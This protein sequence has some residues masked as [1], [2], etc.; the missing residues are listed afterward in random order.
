MNNHHG[1]GVPGPRPGHSALS[2]LITID[3]ATFADTYWGEQPLYTAA[4]QL[5]EDFADLLSSAA[6]DELVS[7]R[8]LR[9]PFLRVAKDGSTLPNQAFS[10]PGGAGAAINDQVS[11]DKLTQLFA[12][13]AT[14]VLQALHR[15]WPPV[16]NFSQ[17]LAAEL[18]H[19]VQVNAYIT[20]PQNKGFSDHYDVHDVFLLQVEGEKR[21]VIHQPVH[22]SPLRDQP[23]T[24]RTAAVEAAA[25][26]EPLLDI[27]LQPGDCLYLPR[28]YLHAATAL[29]G[30]SIHLTIGIHTWNRHGLAAQLS[31]MA[32][33]RLA[34]DP[35]L[36]ASLPAGVNVAAADS[37]HNDIA[38]A[39]E[40]LI[41][42]IQDATPEAVAES[43]QAA[44]RDAQRAAPIGPLA[45]LCTLSSLSDD[46]PVRLRSHLDPQLQPVDGGVELRCRA[47]RFRCTE[48]EAV[49]VELLLDGRNHQTTDLGRPLVERLIRAGV[50]VAV[51]SPTPVHPVE[52]GSQPTASGRP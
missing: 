12:D 42:A 46:T 41:Q 35:E 34:A 1:G 47:G 8:G 39:K 2:R 45:Q 17:D 31:A 27:V 14:M 40:R 49:A 15:S 24:N 13:G 37:I 43:M 16:I 52:T 21:W 4:D 20:P 7:M 36:R 38:L 22:P 33:Q 5:N 23:W 28:G 26:T 44:Q 10:A 19:P 6:V 9:T 48:A 29:G 25:K 30:V 32:V 3:P 18:G 51:P 11:D 50:L